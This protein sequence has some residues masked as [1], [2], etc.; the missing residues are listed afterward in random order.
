MHPMAPRANNGDCIYKITNEST[1]NH[2]VIRIDLGAGAKRIKEASLRVGYMWPLLQD[3]CSTEQCRPI[4]A[5]SKSAKAVPGTV[6]MVCWS[7]S[8][9]L[10]SFPW[11]DVVLEIDVGFLAL[12]A[13][14]AGPKDAIPESRLFSIIDCLFPA[15]AMVQIVVLK[16]QLRVEQSQNVARERGGPVDAQS[17]VTHGLGVEDVGGAHPPRGEIGSADE[18]RQDGDDEDVEPAETRECVS[19]DT[20]KWAA[21]GRS[22]PF[23]DIV[24]KRAQRGLWMLGD[25]VEAVELPEP[26][27]LVHQSVVPGG[28]AGELDMVAM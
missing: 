15:S 11:I 27:H 8:S 22:S 20:V 10:I 1:D 14:A 28:G 13:L 7:N 26:W 16:N 2:A 6:P 3:G 18:V 19:I 21:R 24:R 12:D 4:N 25:V 9:P 23:L 17:R 5:L